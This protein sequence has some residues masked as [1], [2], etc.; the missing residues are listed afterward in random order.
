MLTDYEKAVLT[1]LAAQVGL[2]ATGS[3]ADTRKALALARKGIAD[4]LELLEQDALENEFE[5]SRSS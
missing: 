1:L 5:A 4:A 2:A 3:G